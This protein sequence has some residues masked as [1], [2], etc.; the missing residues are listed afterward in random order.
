[1]CTQIFIYLFLILFFSWRKI[2]ATKGIS[3]VFK[4]QFRNFFLSSPI[5][6]HFP[7]HS[8]DGML[9][10]LFA[11]FGLSLSSKLRRW[12][13]ISEIQIRTL[14]Q[15][16]KMKLVFWEQS[17]NL[18]RNTNQEYCISPN[19]TLHFDVS[20]LYYACEELKTKQNCWDFNGI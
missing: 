3:S 6:F 18:E 1:M 10:W 13:I 4:F 16:G 17:K 5:R 8:L 9:E 20:W 7:P 12:K 11:S 2:A 15:K 19:T 14:H